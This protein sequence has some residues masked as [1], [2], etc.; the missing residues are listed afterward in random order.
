MR[1]HVNPATGTPG[2]CSALKACPFG[3]LENEH[4][5]NVKEARQAFEQ[6]MSEQ[7]V[8]T[9]KATDDYEVPLDIVNDEI[10]PFINDLENEDARNAI[11]NFI[12]SLNNG[13]RLVMLRDINDAMLA[14]VPE[15]SGALREAL[16]FNKKLAWAVKEYENNIISKNAGLKSEEML[17]NDIEKCNKKDPEAV[18]GNWEKKHY[19]LTVADNES[20]GYHLSDSEFEAK[21]REELKQ[22]LKEL[23]M[24]RISG[25]NNYLGDGEDIETAGHHIKYFVSDLKLQETLSNGINSGKVYRGVVNS[26]DQQEA[27]K[28]LSRIGEQLVKTFQDN[29]SFLQPEAIDPEDL[30]DGEN[31]VN[32]TDDFYVIGSGAENNAYLHKPSGMVFKAYHQNSVKNTTL[33]FDGE[34]EVSKIQSTIKKIEERYIKINREGLDEYNAEYIPTY[35][36]TSDD[37]RGNK[38]P[39]IAQPY[40]DPDLYVPTHGHFIPQETGVNDLHAGNVRVN[41]KTK[42]VV[43][44]D[45][46]L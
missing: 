7:T 9:H 28:E 23:T 2:K 6:M 5:D 35:F 22:A 15:G 24:I 11:R 46:I 20:K 14:K 27:V 37:G 42:R 43:L 12:K 13:H 1:F 32:G 40:L 33:D 45:C 29:D 34:K 3:D 41:I 10:N 4:Y 8:I 36:I 39:L 17:L 38:V 44:F 18:D 30:E 25:I 26:E 19:E 21:N 16:D 31:P